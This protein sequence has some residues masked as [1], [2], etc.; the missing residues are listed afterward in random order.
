MRDESLFIS[1]LHLTN[2]R[3]ETVARFLNFLTKRAGESH[4]LYVLGD[5]FD[6]Y[7]GD[8][9]FSSPLKEIRS[10]FRQL[11]HAGVEVSIQHGNRDFLIGQNFTRDTGA[12]LMEDETLIDLYGV[13]T[14]L[15]HGDLLCTDDLPYQAARLRIRTPEWKTSALQKPLWLRK[16]YARWY[17]Y[18]SG[19]DKGNKTLEIMDANP[20]A[21]I[22]MAERHRAQRMIHG[23]THRPAI[24]QHVTSLGPLER[25][26]L[27][28]WDG[29]EQVLVVDQE[30]YR[31][32]KLS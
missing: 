21:I 16:L 20:E 32:E 22:A 14:L 23:H 18:K 5:L 3:P 28:E 6:V 12:T 10:K 7:L 4:K 29:H 13:Q 8:D 15:T 17:R 25:I 19:V 30:G 11:T 26:V 27:P 31:M 24:H 1:D 2:A 9:D